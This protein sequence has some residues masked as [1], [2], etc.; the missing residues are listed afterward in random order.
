MLH[1]I[2]FIQSINNIGITLSMVP[3]SFENRLRICPTHKKKK[4]RN[5]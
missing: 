4:K 1:N 3:M 5:V 2:T